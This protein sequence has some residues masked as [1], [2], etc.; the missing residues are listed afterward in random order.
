MLE[1][2]EFASTSE[3]AKAEKINQSYLCRILRLTLLAP[4]IVEAAINGPNHAGPELKDLMKGF[5]IEWRQQLTLLAAE[6][7]P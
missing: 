2:G 6:V 3:L 7:L 1:S 5:S 4:Q